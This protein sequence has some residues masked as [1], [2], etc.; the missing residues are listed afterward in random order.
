MNEYDNKARVYSDTPDINELRDDFNRVRNELGWWITRSEENR[1]VRFNLWPNKSED[2]RKH[3]PQAWPWDNASDLEVFHTDNLITSSVAM[4]KSSLKK[5]NL[6][7]AP[8]E[9][10]DVAN[11]SM[12]TEFMKWLVFSQMDELSRESEVLAN[13]VLEKGL[14]ILGVYWKREVQ[15]NYRTLTIAKL[16]RDP[17]MGVALETNDPGIIAELMRNKDAS[18]VDDDLEGKILEL[19]EGTANV[20]YTVNEVTC[21]RPY[22]KTY[23]LGRDILIDANVMDLQ[24]ARSIYCLHYFTPEELKGKVH[25]DGW[26]EKFVDDAIEHYTGDSPS[27]RQS[28]PTIFPN[29]DHEQKQNYEGLIQV[30]CSYRREVDEN[31]VPIMSM[32]VFTER[33]EDEL[34]ATHTTITTSPAQYPFIAFPREC[35]TQRLFDSRGWPE[36]LR[37]YEYGIKTERDARR[38]QAS[39]STVPPLEYV[40]GRAPASIGPG[41]KIPV[42][43]RGE[44]GY[45]EIPR[46]SPASTEVENSLLT[47]SYKVTGRP[48]DEA[49]AVFANVLTQ[50]MVDNWLNGWKQ[51]LNQIW[52]LQKSYGD[53]KV[54]FRVTNNENG[55]EIYMD[56]TGNKYDIELSWNTLNADEDKQL[57]KLEKVGTIMSQ[58]D[59]NGQVDFGEFTRVF[60]ESIDANLATKL[61]QP[62]ET[63]T[64]REE[65][66][67]SADIAKIAS[68]Q[69]VNAPP[70]ANAE[71]RM[72]V[73]QNWLQG[74]EDI[75]GTDI[76]EKLQQDEGFQARLQTYMGQLQQ[77]VQ[78]QKNAL[79]GKLGTPPGNMPPTSY[80]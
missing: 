22:I 55:V 8:V 5:S 33:G 38:D 56:E 24:S 69:V 58:F 37:G 52:S 1:N 77:A 65:E 54:W 66:E 64:Q 57:E 80:G 45:M 41:A 28:Q 44:V 32:T 18:I 46:Y 20:R 43:R 50:S 7:C 53:D 6:I 73:I 39:L 47:Q 34:Y 63:A 31:G 13:N 3:G 48:T 70:N 59:R 67:T 25:S 27:V 15:K 72:S 26:D 23:E 71:L 51:V 10:S 11:A 14:G 9:S 16:M 40:V 35:V 78:Q 36:L 74:T 4:L 49:D 2:G 60:V 29:R 17:D 42:R 12:V 62:K 61:I 76:Q 75:P 30:I 19:L 79:I 68:G 21:N